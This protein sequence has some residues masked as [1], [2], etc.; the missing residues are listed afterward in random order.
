MQSVFRIREQ[1]LVQTADRSEKIVY[2][3]SFL[4]QMHGSIELFG[5]P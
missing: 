5:G 4:R 2:S 3:F 1:N